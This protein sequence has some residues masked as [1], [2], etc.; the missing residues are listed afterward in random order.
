MR[1]QIKAVVFDYDDTLADTSLAKKE[2][3]SRVAKLLALEFDGSVKLGQLI[4][5]INRVSEEMNRNLVYDRVI[6]WR[7]IGESQGF[8]VSKSLAMRATIA[9]WNLFKRFTVP[10]PDAIPLL[11]DLK[12]RG[13]R[14][15]MVTDTDGLAGIK[16]WRLSFSPVVD[17]LEVIIVS[18]EDTRKTKPD[19]Y[20]FKLCAEKL[21]VEPSQT[22]FVGDK[23]YTDVVGSKSA[24]M[25]SV[26]VSRRDWQKTMGADYVVKNLEEVRCLVESVPQ[27]TFRGVLE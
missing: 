2:A 17:F 16:R 26:L 24:G 13:Y 23:P 4:S 10:F 6:W 8:E 27:D 20:P 25:T 3:F 12:T 15:G 9:Y 5:E 1:G 22:I 21:G 18:G 19:P 11:S 14:L 7:Q